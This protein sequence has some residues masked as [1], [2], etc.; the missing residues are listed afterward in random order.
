MFYARLS[1][2]S[3][4]NTLLSDNKNAT[5]LNSEIDLKQD[6]CIIASAVVIY[7]IAFNM[8]NVLCKRYYDVKDR[9][10]GRDASIDIK[11]ELNS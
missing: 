1:L 2:V 4:I 8:L 6:S 5:Y 10:T 7:S 3:M 11:S 9:T